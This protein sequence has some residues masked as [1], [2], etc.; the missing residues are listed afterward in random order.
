MGKLE[1][2]KAV[3]RAIAAPFAL[4]T[5]VAGSTI[6]AYYVGLWFDKALA[7]TAP[8]GTATIFASLGFFGSL[9][10]GTWYLTEPED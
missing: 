8:T 9:A 1:K 4:L 6:L 7:G 3:V 10:L 5:G 2:L